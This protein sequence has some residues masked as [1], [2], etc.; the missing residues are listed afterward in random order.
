MR[1]ADCLT[2]HCVEGNPGRDWKACRRLQKDAP[3]RR[4][5]GVPFLEILDVLVC[6]PELLLVDERST[7]QL[8][9]RGL[10]QVELDRNRLVVAL[11]YSRSLSGA[12]SALRRTIPPPRIPTPTLLGW[13]LMDAGRR[14]TSLSPPPA[15]PISPSQRP[16]D[17]DIL[18]PLSSGC[19]LAAE[20][21][22]CT[23]TSDYCV[24]PCQVSRL[25][26]SRSQHFP[27]GCLPRQHQLH[28]H[29]LHF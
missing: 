13:A 3:G 28:R 2:G 18:P 15:P 14:W 25:L 5:L 21:L 4:R 22:R 8:R 20:H 10:A 23:C 24:Q 19:Q 9:A 27:C 29:Q 16:R 6:E 7:A 26:D 12:F 17:S 11:R 1:L